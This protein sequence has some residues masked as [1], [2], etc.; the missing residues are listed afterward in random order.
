M[1][2]H[3]LADQSR[4]DY[5][6]RS[7]DATNVEG[8][9]WAYE[10]T[11][12]SRLLAMAEQ[13]WAATIVSE[14]PGTRESGDLHPQRV[15]ANTAIHAHGVTYA[16]KSK[17]PA[18]LYLHSGNAEYLRFAMAAQERIM[19]HHM[20]IDGIPSTSEDYRGTTALDAHETCDIS[21][22]TWSWGYLL[23]AT[24][25][26][27][28]A[29]RIE[30]AC[31]NAGLGAIR[32]DW[33]ALQY[34]SCPNQVIAT[35]DSSHVPADGDTRGWM[36]YRP[37]PGH[38]SSCCGGNVHRLLPNYVIRMWMTGADGSVAAMLY[39]AS[40]LRTQV[41]L[42]LQQIEIRQETDYP[43]GE[44]IEL[45]VHTA[46]PVTFPLLLRIPGWCRSPQ[47]ALNGVPFAMPAVH[48]GFVRLERSFEPDDRI[49]LTVP[50][51]AA[52][53]Y[54]SND[55]PTDAI[56]LEHGPLVYSLNIEADWKPVFTEKWAS[57]EFP[58]WDA[59]PT[60]SW[61]YG[62]ASDD[63]AILSQVRIARKSMTADPWLDPPVTLTVNMKM[64]PEWELRVASGAPERKVTPPLPRIDQQ[65]WN[66]LAQVPT[67][68]IALVP[69]GSTELRLTIFPRV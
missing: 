64:V 9:L 31:F 53:T 1:R 60:S 41:G 12:D 13:A 32:K 15:Y 67:Q 62:I 35:Q 23:M 49:T 7:R 3:Y 42:R 46:T 28:W 30:R 17:L 27:R 37:N 63:G 43:F 47:L 52:F 2:R 14:P 20:L 45:T 5:G 65:L 66:R 57:R 69:Y 36:A 16:E 10:R 22:H 26:G 59:F 33:K 61:N 34:F 54:W 38:K 58:E 50:M 40:T 11:G 44:T 8:M 25:D 56:G 68:Q 24:G 29:D 48:N 51:T 39:G 19:S 21:D 4:I 6:G 55:W 18:I